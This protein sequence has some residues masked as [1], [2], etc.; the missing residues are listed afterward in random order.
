MA[1]KL[2]ISYNLRQLKKQH[3]EKIKATFT[4]EG[5]VLYTLHSSNK[6][7]Q[8]SSLSDLAYIIQ[9]NS[10]NG[11]TGMVVSDVGGAVGGC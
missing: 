8:V 5:N 11:R 1:N 4:R 10:P 2:K 6:V 9:G 3:P 7:Y